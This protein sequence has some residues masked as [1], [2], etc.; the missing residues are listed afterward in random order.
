MYQKNIQKTCLLIYLFLIST[1]SHAGIILWGSAEYGMTKSQVMSFYP[2]SR[3]NEI[4]DSLFDGSDALL[5]INDINVVN[6]HFIVKFYFKKD[7]LTQVS[8]TLSEPL[9]FKE[10]HQIIDSI[11]EVLTAKYGLPIATKLTDY[12]AD[13]GIDTISWFSKGV[14]ISIFVISM[15]KYKPSDFII[16]YQVRLAKEM[17]SL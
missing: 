7:S 17:K 5:R 16:N 11:K 1:L 8:L 4:P 6:H 14:N 10:T 9:R 15:D 3:N 2:E 12:D 13:S